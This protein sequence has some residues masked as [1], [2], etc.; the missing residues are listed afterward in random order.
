MT[1]AALSI[2]N[3]LSY[4]VCAG[5]EEVE[6][7]SWS[8]EFRGRVAF[9]NAAIAGS[10]ETVGVVEKYDSP[11]RTDERYAWVLR[12]PVL[13]DEP[14]T[15]VK[16]KLRFFEVEETDAQKSWKRCR[17]PCGRRLPKSGQAPIRKVAARN[18]F[19][20]MRPRQAAP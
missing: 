13:F 11:W 18:R 17:L 12:N 5:L 6:S 8:T 10:V 2:R 4:L 15:G 14:F 9:L 1:V 7:R 3:P 16:G 20:S 19:S